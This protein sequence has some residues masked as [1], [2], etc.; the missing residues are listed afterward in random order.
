MLGRGLRADEKLWERGFAPKLFDRNVQ[1]G[2]LPINVPEL[3]ARP[4]DARLPKPA[5]HVEPREDL[6]SPRPDDRCPGVLT[7][8]VLFFEHEHRPAV[9]GQAE[10]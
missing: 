6:L 5:H 9:A 10:R 2:P 1:K 3:E 7:G 4:N 8:A